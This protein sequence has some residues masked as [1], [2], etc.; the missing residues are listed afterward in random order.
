MWNVRQLSR[1]QPFSIKED[2]WA[3]I[4]IRLHFYYCL[5]NIYT[6]RML[7]TCPKSTIFHKQRLQMDK[8]HPPTK[9][10]IKASILALSNTNFYTRRMFDTCPKSTIFNKQRLQIDKYG[11]YSQVQYSFIFISLSSIK[12]SILLSFSFLSFDKIS[13]RSFSMNFFVRVL[14]FIILLFYI[15]LNKFTSK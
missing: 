12:A 13:F 1:G 11:Q 10:S 6:R 8:Y 5:T 2:G 14:S 15:G 3:I 9:F 4:V 7:D